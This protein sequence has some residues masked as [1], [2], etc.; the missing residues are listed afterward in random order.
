M[1]RQLDELPHPQ[2]AGLSAHDRDLLAEDL[3]TVAIAMREQANVLRAARCSGLE[4]AIVTIT[5]LAQLVQQRAHAYR[6][7][8]SSF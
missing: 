1:T 5:D 6:T 7:T 2:T 3:T 4:T 8:T